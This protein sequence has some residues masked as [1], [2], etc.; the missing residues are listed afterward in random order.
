MLGLPLDAKVNLVSRR[1]KPRAT[2]NK[3]W[4][5][6]ENW[7]QSGGLSPVPANPWTVAAYARS[8]EDLFR[9]IT[10]RR[11]I[12]ELARVHAEKT[13]KR[14]AHH[15]LVQR[16]LD[17]INRLAEAV[18]R[19]G[20]LFADDKA[21]SA[22]PQTKPRCTP[23]AKPEPNATPKSKPTGLSLSGQPRLV[24]RHKLTR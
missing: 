4:E 6:F 2:S 15:P 21:L 19:D 22:Y 16:N 9:P 3:A 5:A 11:H 14:L 12:D 10:I 13:R 17:L 24:S 1:R 7:C 20:A 18:K 8:L 23:T